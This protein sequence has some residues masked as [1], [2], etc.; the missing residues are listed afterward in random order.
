MSIARI[1]VLATTL[2]PIEHQTGAQ[3]HGKC[4]LWDIRNH[5]KSTTH[6]LLFYIWGTRWFECNKQ[7]TLVTAR[8]QMQ[9]L[10][11]LQRLQFYTWLPQSSAQHQRNK[12]LTLYRLQVVE[13]LKR[14]LDFDFTTKQP[15]CHFRTNAHDILQSTC[16]FIGS[17]A[18]GVSHLNWMLH[19]WIIETPPSRL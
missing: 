6:N 5:R 10:M 3:S 13:N 12:E 9:S 16:P 8:T 14:E 18:A 7:D 17:V 15:C 2:D 11:R 1:S 4:E 19:L